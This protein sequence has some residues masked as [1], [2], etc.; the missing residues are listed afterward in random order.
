MIKKILMIILIFIIIAILVNKL[1]AEE[2]EFIKYCIY[3]DT[4]PFILSLQTEGLG[5]GLIFEI[6]FTNNF[7][8]LLRNEFFNF[9][10]IDTKIINFMFGGRYYIKGAPYGFFIG[11]YFMLLYGI[12]ENNREF[13]WGVNI[14]LGY[15]INLFRELL[16]SDYEL[17]FEIYFEYNYVNKSE[18]IY[19]ISPGFSLGIIF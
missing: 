5:Y 7:S 13:Q 11:S 3:F 14:D 4:K 18:I 6:I 8:I 17:F 12:I 15:K 1:E 9:K 10:I 19:G 2:D 16:K